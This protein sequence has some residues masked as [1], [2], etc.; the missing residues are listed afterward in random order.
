MT[1]S[2]QRPVTAVELDIP[3]DR[4][5]LGQRLRTPDTA[6]V[7]EVAVSI[8]EVGL[9][10]L[11]TV[12]PLEGED[13][14]FKLV[15]GATRVAAH[16]QLGLATVRCKVRVLTDLDARQMEVDE[17]LIR[18]EVSGLDFI[19]H[20]AE[21]LEL[22]AERH[23]EEVVAEPVRSGRRGRPPKNFVSLTK[24]PNAYVRSLMGFA[25][26]TAAEARLSPRTVYRA[27]QAYAGLIADIPRLRGTWIAKNEGVLRQLASLPEADKAPVIDILLEGENR[28]VSD[29]LAKASGVIPTQTARTPV[30]ETLKA[31]K[32]LWGKASPVAREA[33]LHELAG[34]PLPGGWVVERA[35]A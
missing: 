7:A 16:R 34:K 27:C 3:L 1:A 31:F 18:G 9:I 28:S 12:R 23:P 6:R 14:L 24:R 2:A 8:R 32:A 29:A 15:A 5:V 19:L 13:G 4:I 30:D 22:Y 25:E 11:P 33:I 17:N 26:E 20:V 10:H 35:D 21:R